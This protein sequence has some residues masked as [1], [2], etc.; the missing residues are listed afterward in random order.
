MEGEAFAFDDTIEHQ[1]ANESDQLRAILILDG[2]N[3]HLTEAEQQLL[4]RFFIVSDSLAQPKEMG[5]V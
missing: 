5:N 3:P 1:A 2:W 4:R